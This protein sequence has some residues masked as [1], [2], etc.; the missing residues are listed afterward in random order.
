MF[1]SADI[2]GEAFW[3]SLASSW[4]FTVKTARIWSF[5]LWRTSGAGYWRERKSSFSRKMCRRCLQGYIWPTSPMKYRLALLLTT[6]EELRVG[7][8][9]PV[10]HWCR[11][12]TKRNNWTRN[13]NRVFIRGW[14]WKDV[15]QGEDWGL[16]GLERGAADQMA[17][18]HCKFSKT[19][20][21]GGQTRMFIR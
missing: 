15:L 9:H 2:S 5:P 12:E 11:T 17:D 6:D 20:M 7:S 4:M 1:L 8:D 13:F 19:E 18:L 14:S 16:A 10:H 21:G 3:C